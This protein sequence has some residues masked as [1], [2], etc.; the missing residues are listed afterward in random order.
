MFFMSIKLQRSLRLIAYCPSGKL[1]HRA[2][3]YAPLAINRLLGW[4][5]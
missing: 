3:L 2:M 5:S 4:K 1:E